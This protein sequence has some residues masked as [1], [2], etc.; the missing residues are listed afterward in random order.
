MNRNLRLDLHYV[1]TRYRGW[2]RQPGGGTIQDLLEEA[3]GRILRH[4]VR[5]TGAGRTDAG[6]HARGQ[7]ANFAT[8]NPLPP[9][10]IRRG[11]NALL[12]DDIR[13][14]AACEAPDHF[15]ARRDAVAKH[16]AYRFAVGE[17]VSPFTGPFVHHV[18][19]GADIERMARGAGMFVGEHDFTSF[20]ASE[21]RVRNRVRRVVLSRVEPPNGDGIVVFHIAANG[22]L[23][24]MVRTLAGTL[25]E[26]GRGRLDPDRIPAILAGRDRR[27]AGPCAPARGLTLE[28]VE[29][30]GDR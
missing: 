2:Q 9:P 27:L 8:T 4:R 3:L 10:R 15:H 18:R 5:L 13:I 25:V 19:G 20:C 30:G 12:P 17:V 29:Y 24:H 6:V 14:V 11:A 23:Q 26:I 16:Y 7:V 21:C 22:F 28:R 1:G